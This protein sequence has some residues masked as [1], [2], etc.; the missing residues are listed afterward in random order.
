MRNPRRGRLA[1]FWTDRAG[2]LA[3]W[4]EI[5]TL[6]YMTLQASEAPAGDIRRSRAAFVKS[7]MDDDGRSARYVAGRVGIS[8]TALSD[9]LKGKA[10]F[11]ADE[12]E[13]IAGVLKI[14]P[15]DFYAAYLA[16]GT[17]KGPASEEAGPVVHPLGLEPRTH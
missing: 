6:W 7:L 1:A 3:L 4:P 13:L 10:P 17:Q 11:L 14:S 5:R 9:R 12:L 8:H 15:V 16:A 2:S